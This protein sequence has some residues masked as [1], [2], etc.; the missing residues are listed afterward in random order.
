MKG[1]MKLAL[2]FLSVGTYAG[3]A[4]AFLTQ[5]ALARGL[6]PGAFGAFQTALSFVMMVTPLA[7][8]GIGMFWLRAF[9]EEGWQ[10][11]RWIRPSLKFT[12]LST[13]L[14]FFFICLWGYLAPHDELGRSLIL[15][16]SFLVLGQVSIDLSSSVFQLE[17]S[18][19]KLAILQFLP[20]AMRFFLLILLWF[21]SGQYF[22]ASSVAVAFAIVALITLAIGVK[23]ILKAYHGRLALVGHK[24]NT[25]NSEFEVQ[26]NGWNVFNEAWPFGLA[27]ILYFIYFQSSIILV[28]YIISNE[29]AAQYSVA[30]TIMTAIYLFPNLIYQKVMLPKIHRWANQDK[31]KLKQIYQKG[32]L[33]MLLLGVVT[34]AAVHELAP[35]IVPLVFG[36]LYRPVPL[37]LE[38]LAIAIPFRFMATSVGAVLITRNNMKKKVIY[39]VGTAVVSVLLSI[40]VIPF[41]G[42]E[43][44]AYIAVFAEAFQLLIYFYAVR[45]VWEDNV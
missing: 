31:I 8:F 9:G 2:V 44:A 30:I 12:L 39:M 25:H 18:Y 20:S 11:F 21:F 17:E 13:A 29:A 35:Y 4:L 36:E 23:L 33:F 1:S 45:K 40:I 32:N 42:I 28:S 15:I 10:A 22:T 41:G 14:V 7:G 43:G 3:A 24:K 26:P 34:A 16:L 6:S 19:L 5:V 37:V 38:I 27:G